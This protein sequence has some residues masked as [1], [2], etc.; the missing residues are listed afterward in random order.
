[1]HPRATTLLLAAFA[2]A[3]LAAAQLPTTTA[4]SMTYSLTW[5]DIGGNF[6]GNIDP[7][8]SALIRLTVSFSNQNHTGSFSPNQGPFGSGTIRG[9]AFS[10]VDLNGTSDNGG[11]ANGSWNVDATSGYGVPAPWN[12]VGPGG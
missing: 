8:E 10:F 11:N 9:F 4:S 7:G 2:P 5:P 1:M 3:G 12:L 6:D